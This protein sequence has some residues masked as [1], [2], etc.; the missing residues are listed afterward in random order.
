MV[1]W[2]YECANKPMVNIPMGLIVLFNSPMG[3]LV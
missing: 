1:L 2:V 3:L